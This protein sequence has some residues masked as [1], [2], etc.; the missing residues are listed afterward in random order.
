MTSDISGDVRHEHGEMFAGAHSHDGGAPHWHDEFGTHL[1]EDLTDEERTA[2]SLDWNMHNVQLVTVAVDIGSSTSHLMFSRLLI[3]LVGEEP[4]VRSVLVGREVLAESP[5]ILTPYLTDGSIDIEELQDLIVG[6]YIASSAGSDDVDSG[7]IIITGEA[8]KR[9]NAREIA[10]FFAFDT[11]NFVC[12]SA[13]H[14]LEA[15]LAANGSGTVSL[16]RR[17]GRTL[18]NI[19]IGGGTTKLA[20]VQAGEIVATAAIEIG[21]RL[22]VLDRERRLTRVAEPARR[23][24][25]SLGIELTLGGTLAPEH[26]ARLVAAWVDSLAALIASRPLSS[27]AAGLLLTEPLPADIAPSAITISGGVSEFF[28]GRETTDFGDLGRPIAEA[29][30]AMVVDGTIRIPV[31]MDPNLGIRATAVGASLFTVQ[32]GVNPYLSDESVL[33]LRNVPVLAPRLNLEGLDASRVEAALRASMTHVDFEEG[34]DPVA[35]ALDYPGDLEPVVLDALAQ[36]IRASLPTMTAT[37]TPLIL[38]SSNAT[39]IEVG[40]RLKDDLGIT[41]SVLALEG[42]SVSEFDFIDVAEV[43]RPSSVVPVT[44]KSLLFAGGL[45]QQSVKQALYDAAMSPPRTDIGHPGLRLRYP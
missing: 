39:G 44:I 14:H 27:A 2:R 31:V 42:I 29:L 6:A 38:L 36:G 37:G 7:A 18:L 21:A 17:D 11:G 12:A 23:F 19:D 24:A 13:G 1:S 8:L 10:E 4:N 3:Q 33:P 5:I 22:L 28:F 25:E 15:T 26:E 41:S 43:I 45:D 20:L 32:V 35:I 16:S 40:R 30:H 34:N 9:Q